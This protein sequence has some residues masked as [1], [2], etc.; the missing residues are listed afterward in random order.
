MFHG[1][2]FIQSVKRDKMFSDSSVT[3]PLTPLTDALMLVPCSIPDWTNIKDVESSV[4][5]TKIRRALGVT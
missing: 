3:M 1:F 4:K 5:E 2:A